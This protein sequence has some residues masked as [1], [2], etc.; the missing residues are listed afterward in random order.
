MADTKKK[1]AEA[2][3]VEPDKVDEAQDLS[4]GVPAGASATNRRSVLMKKVAAM[5]LDQVDF[6]EKS[7]QKMGTAGVDG[8]DHSKN[9]NSVKTH[10]HASV[11]EDIAAVFGENTELTEEFK[12]KVVGLFESALEAREA[13]IKVELEEANEEKIAAEVATIKE[14]AEERVKE[15]LEYLGNEWKTANKV[16]VE[17][18]LTTESTLL[19]IEG[20]KK[21][22]VEH[23][24][25]IPEEKA[26]VVAELTK[27]VETLE[28][29]LNESVAKVMEMTESAKTHAKADVVAKASTG[30][31]MTDVEKLKK[32]SEGL[33]YDGDDAKFLEKLELLKKNGLK[34]AVKDT[35]I[36]TEEVTPQEDDGK[37]EI[38]DPGMKSLVGAISRTV[39]INS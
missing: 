6:F 17:S 12:D 36:V 7:L 27:K 32:L 33:E 24:I 34:A 29:K 18:S 19:F 13:I 1:K 8:G 15:Y 25:D 31:T 23:Y 10:W 4:A 26:D 37:E 22:F 39:K 3:T 14:A 2:K 20:L 5:G 9:T 11:K 35:G 16:E 28:G 21:L 38:T 30:L